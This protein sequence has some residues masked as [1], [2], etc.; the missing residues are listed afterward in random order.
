MPQAILG[1]CPSGWSTPARSRQTMSSPNE[2]GCI[3]GLPEKLQR[4]PRGFRIET[5]QRNFGWRAGSR[6]S[7]APLECKGSVLPL[8]RHSSNQVADYCV[9]RSFNVDKTANLLTCLSS[10][11]GSGELV[12]QSSVRPATSW[13]AR[14]AESWLERA[15]AAM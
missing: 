9:I 13:V 10:A 2:T 7:R 12:P 4:T 15:G 11:T 8:T 3:G 5:A 6:N 14:D 1:L